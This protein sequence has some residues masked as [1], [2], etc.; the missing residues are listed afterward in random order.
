MIVKQTK[1]NVK[2]MTKMLTIYTIRNLLEY[3]QKGY[4]IYYKKQHRKY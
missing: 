1:E 2:I 3:M 4:K